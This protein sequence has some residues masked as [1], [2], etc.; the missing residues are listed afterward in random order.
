LRNSREIQRRGYTSLSR[1][2]RVTARTRLT[3][4]RSVGAHTIRQPEDQFTR[5]SPSDE[6]GTF[7][8]VHHGAWPLPRKRCRF[9]RSRQRWKG[10]GMTFFVVGSVGAHPPKSRQ[11][12]N[13]EITFSLRQLVLLLLCLETKAPPKTNP[14]AAPSA[15]PMP[16]PMLGINIPIMRPSPTPI[17]SPIPAPLVRSFFGSDFSIALASYVLIVA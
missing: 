4:I 12:S 6:D 16:I 10:L 14:N 13:R 9:Q 5:R 3:Y 8:C 17:A 11:R 15:M 7:P 2:P 1:L